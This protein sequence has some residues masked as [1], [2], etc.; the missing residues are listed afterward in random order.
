MFGMLTGGL[1]R[2]TAD[3]VDMDA[4]EDEVA[5]GTATREALSAATDRLVAELVGAQVEAGLE[6][7]TD[8]QVRWQG[9]RRRGARGDL[10]GRW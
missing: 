6:L 8:G 4:L 9:S 5:A 10:G 2:I 3:G 7:V 1:P